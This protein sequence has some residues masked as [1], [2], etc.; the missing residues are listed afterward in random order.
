M[1]SARSLFLRLAILL[2]LANLCHAEITILQASP[3]PGPGG[4]VTVY[5]RGLTG[6]TGYT[7]PTEIPRPRSING[8]RV[9]YQG[10][11]SPNPPTLDA[12]I[13]AVGAEKNNSN[14][15]QVVIFQVPNEPNYYAPVL[16]QGDQRVD[17]PHEAAA[18]GSIS[19]VVHST[20]YRPVT[21]SDPPVASEWIT[22]FGY[23]FG[24]VTPQPQEG[25]P[26]RLDSLSR[27][28]LDFTDAAGKAK[29]DIQARLQTRPIGLPLEVDFIG[30]APGKFGYYQVNIRMP[31]T[32]LPA[33]PA[34]LVLQ[35]VAVKM[36]VCIAQKF[37]SERPYLAT[38]SSN[39]PLY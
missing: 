24:P 13:F 20:D 23:N 2:G 18:W 34:I 14:E 38:D 28:Q 29:Y 36:T 32:A 37:C 3:I 26:A 22:V 11:I 33:G 16:V 17:V 19:S 35:R 4:L 6:I 10:G 8:I 25:F 21:S 5:T 31:A 39:V 27:L 30:L 7:V 9:V 15:Y 1:T 12:P